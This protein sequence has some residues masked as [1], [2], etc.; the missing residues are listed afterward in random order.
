MN[1]LKVFEHNY[2]SLFIMHYFDDDVSEPS[3]WGKDFPVCGGQ[4]QSPINIVTHKMRHDPHLTPIIFEGYMQ[5]LNITVHNLGNTGETAISLVLFFL[6]L[7][8]NPC[9]RS[10][11]QLSCN[12]FSSMF[13]YFCFLSLN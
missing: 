12:S 8:S 3:Q 1:E 4:N 9:Q 7:Q 2:A 10:H 13:D 6:L 11:I 5:T